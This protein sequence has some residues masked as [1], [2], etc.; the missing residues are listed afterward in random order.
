[1]ASHR[2][3]ARRETKKAAAAIPAIP[4]LGKLSR[5]RKTNATAA[6]TI[7]AGDIFWDKRKV[8]SKARS[9]ALH[10]HAAELAHPGHHRLTT[11]QRGWLMNHLPAWSWNT[12]T[13]S[14]V[15]PQPLLPEHM[16][17]LANAARLPYMTHAS[18]RL[19]ALDAEQARH[20]AKALPATLQ[21]ILIS[22]D[23]NRQT[24]VR[25]SGNLSAHQSKQAALS[26]LSTNP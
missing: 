19:Q 17:Q 10:T 15:A 21:M 13:N 23:G 26:Y 11:K 14:L 12:A 2:S 18:L 16:G 3:H 7:A 1:M 5:P 22:T 20:I 4:N 25:R 9:A 24:I 6:K 8:A